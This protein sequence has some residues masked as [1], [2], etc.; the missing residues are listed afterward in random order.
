M[1]LDEIHHIVVN[2]WN[3]GV[4][5]EQVRISPSPLP[6][7]LLFSLLYGT[8]VRACMCTCSVHI[9]NEGVDAE[10]VCVC[11]WGG[12]CGGCTTARTY[13]SLT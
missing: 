12:G 5:A 13:M 11:V 6:P 3:K 7:P 4:D 8:Y 2:S 1:D 10:Q 9:W